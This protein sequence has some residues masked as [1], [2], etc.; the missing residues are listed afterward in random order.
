MGTHRRPFV[1]WLVVVS[2]GVSALL[3]VPVVSWAQEPVRNS[4]PHPSEYESGAD[5]G[6]IVFGLPI[7]AIVGAALP[8]GPPLY[9][10]APVAGQTR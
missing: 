7:G 4:K 5:I 8:I 10:A 1:S 9:E 2:L 6:A 3:A